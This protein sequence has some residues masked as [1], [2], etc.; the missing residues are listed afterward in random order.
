LALYSQLQCF[1]PL[2]YMN[3]NLRESHLPEVWWKG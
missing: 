3:C 2:K 1:W